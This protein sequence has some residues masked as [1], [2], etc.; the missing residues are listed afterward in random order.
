MGLDHLVGR[1]SS[2]WKRLEVLFVIFAS[3]QFIKRNE[4]NVPRMFQPLQKYFGQY[5]TWQVV[6][7]TLLARHVAS[8][9]FLLCG[10][11]APEV[12]ARHYS[13]NF[14]R[15]T[16]ILTALDAGFWTA[17][18]I[19]PHF[20]RHFMGLIFT[21]Y[22]LFDAEGADQ[23]VKSIRGQCTIDLMRISWNKVTSP[24]LWTLTFPFRQ[25]I[26]VVK[27]MRIDRLSQDLKTQFPNWNES[28]RVKLY[29]S[30]SEEE[31]QYVHNLVLHLP[32]G[33]FVCMAPENHEE[34]IRDWAKQLGK[35]VA[36]LSVDYGK[37]PEFPYPYALEEC[38]EI[39]KQLCQTNGHIIGV[40]TAS[41]QSSLYNNQSRPLDNSKQQQL[42]YFRRLRISIAGDSAGGNFAIGVTIK[43]ILALREKKQVRK[44]P[45]GLQFTSSSNSIL[46]GEISNQND[47]LWMP[48]GLFIAYGCL[49]FDMA[50]WIAPQNEPSISTGGSQVLNGSVGKSQ[51]DNSVLNGVTSHAQKRNSLSGQDTQTVRIESFTGIDVPYLSVT[52]RMSYFN[53]RIITPELSR[54]MALLYLGTQTKANP[55]TDIFLSPVNCPDDILAEFPRMWMMCGECDPFV[56]DTVIF[57]TRVRN[58][59]QER[60]EQNFASGHFSD[61]ESDVTHGNS[62][63][64]VPNAHIRSPSF[65]SL[66]DIGSVDSA[67]RL[68]DVKPRKSWFQQT[69]S[70]LTGSDDSDLDYDVD[71]PSQPS[72]SR[73]A[74]A[75]RL[76]E[77]NARF[78]A[79][80][81]SD[82]DDY[83]DD[84]EENE[85]G[86]INRDSTQHVTVK[87]YAGLSHAYLN[88]KAFL[89]EA[90]HAINLSGEWLME[91]FETTEEQRKRKKKQRMRKKMQKKKYFVTVPEMRD[92]DNIPSTISLP[93]GA[94]YRVGGS[95]IR[96]RRESKITPVDQIFTQFQQQ[97]QDTRSRRFQSLNDLEIEDD[98]Q[99]EYHEAHVQING[100]FNAQN[101]LQN[102]INENKRRLKSGY[103]GK[104]SKG[105]SKRV[106]FRDHA[107]PTDSRA[108]EQGLGLDRISSQSGTNAAVDRQ[109]QMFLNESDLVNMRRNVLTRDIYTGVDP[110][111]SGY[112]SALSDDELHTPSMT[113]MA[114]HDTLHYQPHDN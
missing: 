103:G 58:A 88:M 97:Q 55:A 85:Y 99:S 6:V 45:L 50:S 11:N 23:K 114:S 104:S 34:V 21:A 42:P 105:S 75:Q 110:Q 70:I 47:N 57:A 26:G 108:E 13:S 102:A 113:P 28:T 51:D 38:F 84:E 14:Y 76:A 67:S 37:A 22:Y 54:A 65:F 74:V 39:F 10:L 16:W 78:A 25:S 5:Q 44:I 94:E 32:G 61:A 4:N 30:G 73:A 8:K 19:R 91:M 83:D 49:N 96:V 82:S 79:E 90:K 18:R 36:I 48:V 60:M 101:P 29:Y 109:H 59:I 46:N 69:W 12:Y 106:S 15:A 7:I 62:P 52:S 112:T 63:N 98:D 3:W 1:P 35:K 53:D 66:D 56:D 64:M 100:D 111:V 71:L 80:A 24:I 43:V 33:G 20:L 87:I 86:D 17:E 107:S 81:S 72:S 31:L 95:E 41:L 40:N 92:E 27:E 9:F 89:P 68:Q 93:I 77:I 2:T